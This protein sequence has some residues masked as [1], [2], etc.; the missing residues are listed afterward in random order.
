MSF[1]PLAC[2]R[3]VHYTALGLLWIGCF[4]PTIAFSQEAQ[5]RAEGIVRPLLKSG[6]RGVEVT[7]LQAVLKLLG[8]YDG[9]VNGFFGDSTMTAVAQFQQAAGLGRDGI[10]GSATWDRLFPPDRSHSSPS[11]APAPTQPRENSPQPAPP[12]AIDFPILRLGMT[13]AAVTRLQERL[14]AIGVFEGAI[15]GVFGAET[16]AAVKAAQARFLLEADGIVGGA[17]WS[18]L[19][20]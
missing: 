12:A 20:R 18:A 15:D 3:L 2:G 14:R 7:E 16:Q 13:G 8:Y 4:A 5:P 11:S 10:V 1:H 9:T 17:T 6:S 19:M